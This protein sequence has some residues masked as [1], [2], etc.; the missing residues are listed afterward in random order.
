VTWGGTDI[1]CERLATN[2]NR[3]WPENAGRVI[4]TPPGG[5]NALRSVPFGAGGQR[6]LWASDNAGQNDVAMLAVDTAAIPLPGEP[7]FGTPVEADTLTEEPLLWVNGGLADPT[8]VWLDAGVIRARRLALS[9]PLGVP[10]LDRMGPVAMAAPFPNPV[11]GDRFTLRFLAPAG[12]A[13]LT[14]FDVTGRRVHELE[15]QTSGGEQSV[16]LAPARPLAPGVYTARLV[17]GAH[18]AS[19]RIVR[20]D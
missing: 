4:A 8:I 1:R 20:V 13:T 11:R 16:T 14:L 3:L 7:A 19:R 9:N 2:G 5:A 18:Q 17:A 15:V 12:Q 10:P 6:L